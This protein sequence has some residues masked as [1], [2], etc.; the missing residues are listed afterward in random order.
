MLVGCW[1]S[2]P[3]LLAPLPSHSRMHA[4]PKCAFG[5]TTALLLSAKQSCSSLLARPQT[6]ASTAP[7][8]PAPPPLAQHSQ[9][10]AYAHPPL[11]HVLCVLL[12]PS[13]HQQRSTPTP[14]PPR[15]LGSFPVLRTARQ[16]V[17]CSACSVVNAH[18]HRMLGDPSLA[19]RL[20]QVLYGLFGWRAR[21]PGQHLLEGGL[22]PRCPRPP[23]RR[24]HHLPGLPPEQ[25]PASPRTTRPACA[26]SSPGTA[27]ASSLG[28][29]ALR[30]V[31]A[32][33]FPPG[34][35][36]RTCRSSPA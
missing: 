11:L 9:L 12:A 5:L 10:A 18:P 23:D 24:R 22:S 15:A 3:G 16:F 33:V 20:T 26:P 6:P 31:K 2:P 28:Q 19:D 27:A 35:A 34:R 1:T 29:L 13:S 30:R 4:W 25:R 36:G 8:R 7:S 17:S 21:R 14:R 32:V